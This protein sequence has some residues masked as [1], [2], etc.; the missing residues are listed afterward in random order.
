MRYP[1]AAAIAAS[2][3]FVAAGMR[4]PARLRPRRVRRSRAGRRAI[5]VLA[6]LAGL[7]GALPCAALE[8]VAPGPAHYRAADLHGLWFGTLPHPACPSADVLLRLDGGGRYA[9]QAHCRATLEALPPDRGHWSVEWDG[10]CLRLL[11]D[12]GGIDARTPPRE[13]ALPLDDLMVLADG[14]CL[15]P[16]EDPRGRSLHRARLDGG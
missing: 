7:A 1:S 14:S 10:T 9:L 5:A 8:P 13:L 11:P 12:A 15:E 3:G 6:L 4:T 2:A 16:V